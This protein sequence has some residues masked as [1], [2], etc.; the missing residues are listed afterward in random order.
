MEKTK[1]IFNP[2]LE[3][4]E[5]KLLKAFDLY[6]KIDKNVLQKYIVNEEED[7]YRI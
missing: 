6:D 4:I 5:K 3:F 1:K 7:G 2:D